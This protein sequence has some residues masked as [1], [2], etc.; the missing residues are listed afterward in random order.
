[1]THIERNIK[2]LTLFNFLNDFRLY[3][4]IAVIYFS[5]VT[6][7]FTLGMS[8]FSVLM[9]TQ[10][11]FELPT[12]IISDLIGRKK[13]IIIGS[14]FAVLQ[15]V[16]Y[17]SG[18]G[19]GALLVGAV[20]G[21]LSQTFFS[22]NNVAL[23]FESAKQIGKEKEFADIS[24]KASSM[25]Q[26]ALGISAFL[27]AILALYFSL[28]ILF[29]ITVIPQTVAL[30]LSFFV[31]EPKFHTKKI[32]TNVYSHLSASLHG[33]FTNRKLRL[34]IISDAIS[35]GV[36]EVMHD[37][38]PAFIALVW[39]TWAIGIYRTII[40]GFSYLSFV[41]AGKLIKKY[42]AT[43]TLFASSLSASVMNFIALLLSNIFSPAI[44][45]VPDLL[46]GANRTAMETLQQKEFSNEQR[47]TMGS[48]SGML[49]SL[50][51]AVAAVFFG[52]FADMYGVVPALLLGEVVLLSVPYLN[53]QIFRRSR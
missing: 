2:I 43:V 27:G 9:I 8:V 3:S 35:E 40:H 52:W 18:L 49:G 28:T 16:L 39:P 7:S 48:L 12:G 32:D 5:Q 24:A 46:Y 17:A 30:I 23:L 42:T 33:F 22:G 1:M 44:L 10:A 15:V 53:Y 45:M 31:M 26:L 25:F 29:W 36:E 11:I 38:R 34:L 20:C 37:F 19:Y 50:L 4:P 21:G 6:G 13:T 47:A 14:A 51:F 41:F